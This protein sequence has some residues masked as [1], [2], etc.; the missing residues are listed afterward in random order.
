MISSYLKKGHMLFNPSRHLWLKV[1]EI[2]KSQCTTSRNTADADLQV[3]MD[4]GITDRGLEDIGDVTSIEIIDKNSSEDRNITFGEPIIKLHWDAH[5]ITN[6]DELYHTVW[7]SISETT[8]I[9]SPVNGV[10]TKVHDVTTKQ[11]KK[12]LSLPIDSETSLFSVLT[13][14]ESIQEMMNGKRRLLVDEEEYWSYVKGLGL[15]MFQDQ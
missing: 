12:Q 11:R 9:V 1:L 15:G 3:L 13:N 14:A 2:P 6:A 4:I 5:L 7:E 10:L 8:N